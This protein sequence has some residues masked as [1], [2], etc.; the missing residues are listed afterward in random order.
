MTDRSEPVGKISTFN[1]IQENFFEE[2][3]RAD[4]IPTNIDWSLIEGM[5][6]FHVNQ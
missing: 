1:G 2:D 3:S 4:G 6:F 5:T